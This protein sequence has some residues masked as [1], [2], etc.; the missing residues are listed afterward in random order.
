[1]RFVIWTIDAVAVFGGLYVILLLATAGA[2][3]LLPGAF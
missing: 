3:A 1:M 2:S